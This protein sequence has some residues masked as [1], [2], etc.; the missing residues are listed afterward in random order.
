[1]PST[2]LFASSIALASL[3]PIGAAHVGNDTNDAN[4]NSKWCL[5]CSTHFR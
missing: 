5:L 3:V 1:M 2:P 4:E